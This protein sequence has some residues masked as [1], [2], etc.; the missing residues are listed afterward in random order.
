MR[1]KDVFSSVL[2]WVKHVGGPIVPKTKAAVRMTPKSLRSGCMMTE[3]KLLVQRL[4]L[5]DYESG[6]TIQKETERGSQNRHSARHTSAARTP[7]HAHYR[8]SRRQLRDPAERRATE[9]AKCDV[10]R[11]ESRRESHLSRPGPEWS[12]IRSSTSALI[13]KTCIATCATSKRC[14]IR[15]MSDFGIEAFRIEGLTGVHTDAES[16]RDRCAHLALGHHARLCA[17]RKYRS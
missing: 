5:V 8:A 12:V 3:R 2:F 10:V 15:T 6:P 9:A 13:A 1:F 14:L 4:G 11:D 7:T 16:C 17:Q